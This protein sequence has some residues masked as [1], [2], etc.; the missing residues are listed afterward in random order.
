MLGAIEGNVLGAC[1]GECVG[2]ALGASDGVAAPSRQRHVGAETY[3]GP[4]PLR[5]TWDEGGNARKTRV[6]RL[7][8][9]LTVHLR[10]VHLAQRVQKQ[11]QAV[12]R[13]AAIDQQVGERHTT[14]A[15][16]AEDALRGRIHYHRA[17]MRHP[18]P[19]AHARAQPESYLHCGCCL[20]SSSS[21]RMGRNECAELEMLWDDEKPRNATGNTAVPPCNISK[22]AEVFHFQSSRGLVLSVAMTL[23]YLTTQFG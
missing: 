23:M 22:A 7:R 19:S 13:D 18:R 6:G 4:S 21:Q 9:G 20:V 12:A 8:E 1:V 15:V 2:P 3:N 14:H 11:R 10:Q 5:Y 16:H 17:A